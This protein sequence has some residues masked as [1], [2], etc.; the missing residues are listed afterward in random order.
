MVEENL[1]VDL[2][3]EVETEV[4]P[5]RGFEVR[6]ETGSLPGE[7]VLGLKDAK[8]GVVMIGKQR[9]SSDNRYSNVL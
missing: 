3:G 9:P 7:V 8:E 2:E 1:E 4:N 5:V 6:V